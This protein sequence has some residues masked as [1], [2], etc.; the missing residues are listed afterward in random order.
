[1]DLVNRIYYVSAQLGSP[2][3]LSSAVLEDYL[4]YNISHSQAARSISFAQMLVQRQS[5]LAIKGAH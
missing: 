3:H 4:F 1:M 5:G 2:V